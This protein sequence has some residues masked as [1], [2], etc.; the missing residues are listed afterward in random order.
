MGGFGGA[1]AEVFIPLNAGGDVDE[2]RVG[3]M[4]DFLLKRGVEGF[5]VGVFGAEAFA[6]TTEERL[7]FFEA[8]C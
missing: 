1:V 8:G 7:W 6:F 4:L 5:Y 2:S 3:S